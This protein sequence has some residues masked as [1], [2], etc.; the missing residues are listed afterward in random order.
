M[1]MPFTKPYSDTHLTKKMPAP[2]NIANYITP[3][4]GTITTGLNSSTPYQSSLLRIRYYVSGIPMF[5]ANLRL[6]TRPL[7]SHYKQQ[8]S[9][10]LCL[11]RNHFLL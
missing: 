3:T 4:V 5:D 2:T 6:S 9:V 7:I 1:E 8:C 10:L 11:W